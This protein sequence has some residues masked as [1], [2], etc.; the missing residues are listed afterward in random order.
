VPKLAPLPDWSGRDV[1]ILGGGPSLRSFDFDRL[2]GLNTI[3]CNQ[4]FMLG[5][6][7][8]GICAFGDYLF[9]DRF[10]N[11]LEDEYDGWVVTN[12]YHGP[13]IPAWLKEFKRL[14]TGLAG[15]GATN[16][17]WNGNTGCLAVN[18][19]LKLGASRVL[20]LGFDLQMTPDGKT[21]WHDKR[22]EIPRDEHYKRFAGGFAT[23]A[24]LLPSIYPGRQV[25]NVSDGTSKLDCFPVISIQDA[26]D[27]QKEK[28]A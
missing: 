5:V 28:A 26:F 11:Q 24:R 13:K 18:L 12:Y 27:N 3:G 22:I 14:E 25:I 15:S 4:A 21:H 20:L 10:I 17:C 1:F 19:A 9:W 7:R 23:V 16:L 8:C 2:I 6:E